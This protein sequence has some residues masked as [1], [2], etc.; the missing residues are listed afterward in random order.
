[1]YNVELLKKM[2]NIYIYI[3]IYIIFSGCDDY[4]PESHNDISFQFIGEQF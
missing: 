2:I 3:Y 4:H 1:M